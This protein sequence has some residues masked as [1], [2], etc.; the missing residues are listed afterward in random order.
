MTATKA[1]RRM[2]RGGQPEIA[3]AVSFAAVPGTTIRGP[4]RRRPRQVHQPGLH[5]WL[6][7]WE[8][9]YP[10][11]LYFFTPG[12]QGRSPWKIFLRC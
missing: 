8:D 9:A 7:G 5:R 11:N 6:S 4:P 12:V 3:V 10:L 1:P 2:E